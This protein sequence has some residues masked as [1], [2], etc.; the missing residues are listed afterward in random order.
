MS[1]LQDTAAN[2]LLDIEA[3]AVHF[4]MRH[5]VLSRA[6]GTVKAVD[7]V[8][9]RLEEGE[10]L[11]LVGESGCGKSTLVRAVVRLVPIT[12]GAIRFEG[13]DLSRLPPAALRRLRPKLQMVFQDPYASLNP[14]RNVYNALAEPMM[15]HGLAK[16]RALPGEVAGLMEKVGLARRDIR[17]YPHEFSGGQRQRIAVAR[18]LA[19]RPKLI[20][21]DEPVSALDVSV[22]AQILNLL[23]RLRAEERLTMMLISH[24]LSVVY[25]M[26]DRIAVMYLGRIVEIGPAEALYRD[27]RHPYTRAL[28]AAIP[29]PDPA[30][31][32]K[33]P[34]AMLEGDPPSPLNPPAGCAFHPRCRH[35]TAECAANSPELDEQ[36][37]GRRVACSRLDAV[38]REAGTAE[39]G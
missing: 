38:E 15:A 14:R 35:A 21:A 5:G 9:L 1:A 22:Q 2:A 29:V 17:K 19:L 8:S 24:D 16:G 11:G 10:V 32:R 6:A 28:I 33:R 27:P 26:A 13:H 36:A 7:G 25:H 4:T 30:A 12:S 34:G 20:L 39:P 3:L 18:A 23:R 37:D 31:A